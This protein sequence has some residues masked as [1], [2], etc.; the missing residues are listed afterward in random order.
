MR[1]GDVVIARVGLQDAKSTLMTLKQFL[2]QRTIGVTHLIHNIQKTLQ[3]ERRPWL[4]QESHQTT[5]D[6]SF[7]YP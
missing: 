1:I 5:L 3:K 7:Q 2:E 4:A 6:S